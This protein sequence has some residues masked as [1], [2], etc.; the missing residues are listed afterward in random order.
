MHAKATSLVRRRSDHAAVARAA[1]NDRLAN[2]LRV[3]PQFNRHKKRIHV[4]MQ[5]GSLSPLTS[6]AA[7]LGGQR[8]QGAPVRGGRIASALPATI[9]RCVE[10]HVYHVRMIKNLVSLVLSVAVMVAVALIVTFPATWLLMLFLG[11]VGLGVSYWGALPLGI[12]VAALLGASGHNDQW[13]VFVR[14]SNS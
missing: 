1:D 11:N 13:N 3:A 14:S 10:G 6:H 4:G 12:L 7:T 2:K 5:Y 8:L 9:P